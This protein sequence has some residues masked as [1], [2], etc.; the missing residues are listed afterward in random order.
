MKITFTHL[1]TQKTPKTSDSLKPT[2][3][4]R[5]NKSPE[6]RQIS[7]VITARPR[8]G[9]VYKWWPHKIHKGR[10]RNCWDYMR[11]FLHTLKLAVRGQSCPHLWV[12]K[13]LELRATKALNIHLK[14]ILRPQFLSRFSRLPIFLLPFSLLPKPFLS[15]H[16]TSWLLSFVLSH[17]GS[18]PGI[19]LL[20]RY[21]SCE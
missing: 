8:L 1:D 13:V 9:T 19:I 7:A 4:K 10:A 15:P 2:L 20:T 18:F 17:P 21:V 14:N 5:S 16:L 3:N 12:S 6:F 11:E